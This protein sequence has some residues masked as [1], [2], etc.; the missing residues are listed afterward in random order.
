MNYLA[1]IFTLCIYFSVGLT[2][3][4]AFTA[5]LI[6]DYNEIK[7][8]KEKIPIY[9][10]IPVLVLMP[11]IYPLPIMIFCITSICSI[12]KESSYNYFNLD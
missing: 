8:K 1:L 3:D 5:P 12:I 11:L 7:S 6:S 4:M 10:I 9:F 2:V